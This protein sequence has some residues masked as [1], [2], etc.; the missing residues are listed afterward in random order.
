MDLK[1]RSMSQRPYKAN[2][3]F[4]AT[5]CTNGINL[6][7]GLESR[8]GLKKRQQSQASWLQIVFEET[9]S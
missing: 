2:F 7:S 3:V 5:L 4:V 8:E 6:C 9:L 1:R